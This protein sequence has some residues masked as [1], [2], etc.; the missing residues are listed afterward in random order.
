MNCQS[1]SLSYLVPAVGGK[2]IG[3][4]VKSLRIAIRTFRLVL[5][6][7][8]TGW[9]TIWYLKD[10]QKSSPSYLQLYDQQTK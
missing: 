4:R 2:T 5:E 3:P 1:F 10:M 8:G 9:C 6:E 7:R